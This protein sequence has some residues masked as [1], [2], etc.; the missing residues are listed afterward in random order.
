ML[1]YETKN[2]AYIS[3]AIVR[4]ND[5]IWYKLII[6]EIVK[7]KN[8]IGGTRLDRL[9]FSSLASTMIKTI[10]H[11]YSSIEEKKANK[12]ICPKFDIKYK[13][14]VWFRVPCKHI[15][16]V[17]GSS[18]FVVYVRMHAQ[19]THPHII[20]CWSANSGVNTADQRKETKFSSDL[21]KLRIQISNRGEM[22]TFDWLKLYETA[23]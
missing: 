3:P 18:M 12:D 19:D 2:N 13:I 4:Q 15:I 6:T 7:E 22:V 20:T 16:T 10:Q 17:L 14:F 1:S 5:K 11:V 21:R 23:V 8:E 9:H